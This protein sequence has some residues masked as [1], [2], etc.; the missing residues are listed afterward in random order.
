M[1]KR[2]LE[3]FLDTVNACNLK[4]VTCVFSDPRVAALP[5]YTMPWEL[6]E[7][8]ARQVF[9]Q[10]EYLTLSCLTEPLMNPKFARYLRFAGEF[11]VPRMEF[12]TNAQLLRD[13]HLQACVDA[14]LWRLAVSLDGGDA[15]SYETVRRGASWERL[16]VNTAH[17]QDFFASAPHRPILRIIITLVQDNFRSAIEAVRIALQWGAGEVELRETLTFPGIGLEARQL[18]SHGAE[19]RSVLLECKALCEAARVPVLILSEN[20]PGLKVDLSGVPPCHALERRVAIAANGDV[21]PCMLW[22]REPLGNLR[23]SSFEQ[24][25]NGPWRARLRD[26]FRRERPLLWCSTCTIC[27]DDPADD[28]AY[29]RLLAKPRPLGP[30]A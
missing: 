9:P 12:V 20:A 30:L 24:V 3:V 4:C 8:V 28:D 11:E 1:P 19:L 13:E 5:K 15:I 18:K 29:F 21:M 2:T 26:Q 17:A 16:L 14:R 22:A 25:W 7:K 10:A 27:K 6:Y 23:D